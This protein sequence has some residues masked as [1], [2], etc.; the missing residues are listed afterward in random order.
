[1]RNSFSWSC[2]ACGEYNVAELAD[3]SAGTLRCAFCLHPLQPLPS[4]DAKPKM[5]LSDEWL[6]DELIRPLF[7]QEADRGEGS[8]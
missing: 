1:M 2:Q 3:R 4:L 5:R 8:K 7:G 6:G